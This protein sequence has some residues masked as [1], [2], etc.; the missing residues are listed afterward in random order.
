V[1]QR[2]RAVSCNFKPFFVQLQFRA[3]SSPLLEAICSKLDLGLVEAICSKLG[4]GAICSQLELGAICSKP[5]RVHLISS[6]FK[7]FVRNLTEVS[8]TTWLN[9]VQLQA[10]C[11]KL[12]QGKSHYELVLGWISCNFKPFVRNL[13]KV[14]LTPWLD[15]V[16]LQALCAKLDQGRSPLGRIAS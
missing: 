6:N 13:T 8:L 1:T 15:F 11:S 14:S 2:K 5:W 4:L 7:P 3:T 10:L 12:D 16:Q 9:L